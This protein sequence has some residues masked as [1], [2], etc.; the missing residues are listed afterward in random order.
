MLDKKVSGFSLLELLLAIAIISLI[1][2]MTM[3]YFTTVRSSQLASSAVQELQTIRS[4][5]NTQI[6]EGI[7]VTTQSICDAIS[8]QTIC[9][10]TQGSYNFIFPWDAGTGNPGS[11]VDPVTAS[12]AM[13]TLQIADIP[14]LMICQQVALMVKKDLV[15]DPPE[16]RLRSGSS[17]YRLILDFAH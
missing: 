4:T 14:S 2:M 6:S 17:T 16:C 8:S 11:I 1:I 13:V 15:G 5:A 3:R 7:S 12:G 9:Y 10:N